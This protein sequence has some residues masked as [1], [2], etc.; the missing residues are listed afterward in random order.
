MKTLAIDL[1]VTE[2][3]MSGGTYKVA[4]K[5]FETLEEALEFL[6]SLSDEEKIKTLKKYRKSCKKWQQK[7]ALNRQSI[8]DKQQKL[9]D[10]LEIKFGG[11]Y[12]NYLR[13]RGYNLNSLYI[14]DSGDV[15]G[16]RTDLN[17]WKK[18]A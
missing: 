3:T 6:N 18:V 11:D 12:H 14:T 2:N 9:T 1:K 17:S 7:I 5:V 8:S 13:D 4:A 15:L 16:F 10:K